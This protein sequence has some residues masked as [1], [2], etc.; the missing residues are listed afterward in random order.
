MERMALET[1]NKAQKV[2][3]LVLKVEGLVNLNTKL[4]IL[5]TK[6]STFRV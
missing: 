3:E 5:I 6:S 2:E 1:E 4:S